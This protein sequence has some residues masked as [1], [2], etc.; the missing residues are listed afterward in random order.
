MASSSEIIVQEAAREMWAYELSTSLALRLR[1]GLPIDV[2]DGLS[3][4]KRKRDLQFAAQMRECLREVTFSELGDDTKTQFEILRDMCELQ[5]EADRFYWLRLAIAPY[6]GGREFDAIGRSLNSHRVT[7]HDDRERYCKLLASFGRY[8]GDHLTRLQA[9][10]AM[11][12]LVPQDAIGSVVD[13]LNVIRA[14][15]PDNLL[16]S[17]DLLAEVTP[18]EL[19][20]FKEVAQTEIQETVATALNAIVQFFS[21]S[22]KARAPRELG[23][24]QY[25]QGADYYAYL[26]RYYTGTNLSP[27]EIHERGIQWVNQ[28]AE[29]IVDCAKPIGLGAD[30]SEIYAKLREDPRFRVRSSTEAE[31]AY[32]KYVDEIEP[33]LATFFSELPAVPYAV[34][35]APPSI[36]R[37]MTYGFY[38]MPSARNHEGIY[39]FNGAALD[40]C[41]L[42]ERAR[43]YHELMPGHHLQICIQQACDQPAIFKESLNGAYTEG[44]AEYASSLGYEMGLYTDPLEDI[45][46]MTQEMFIAVRLVVDSAIACRGW[47]LDDARQYMEGHMLQSRKEIESE[48]L[49]YAT[50]P[51]Q[52]IAYGLGF[53]AFWQ[54]RGKAERELGKKFDIRKFHHALLRNGAMPLNVLETQLDR[55]IAAV[56]SQ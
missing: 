35:R 8:L 17:P 24:A 12:I 42:P 27:E 21:D 25:P 6:L 29:R 56:E 14:G 16:P 33:K 52:A 49:R 45:G 9:Q 54:F 3:P 40:M 37:G 23:V 19:A 43:I 13:T 39:Y 46:R 44:W 15:M 36:E 55:Y 18:D 50:M 10:E 38:A 22:Y 2:I 4:E 30:L 7:T 1:L 5:I 28:I 31:T 53:K 34:R 47:S 20:T 48:I 26:V 51:G 11:G 32:L 41:F